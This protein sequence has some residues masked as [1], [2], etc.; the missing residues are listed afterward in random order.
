[1]SLQTE[2][3]KRDDMR[4]LMGWLRLLARDMMAL[5]AG[6]PDDVLQCPLHKERLFANI[7]VMEGEN[8]ID[9]RAGNAGGGRGT[10]I[11]CE[12]GLVMDGVLLALRQA[13]KEDTQ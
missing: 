11:K 8:L 9:R 2:S 5:R 10:S 6:A 13:L 3:L 1:M 4:E 7:T 12:A